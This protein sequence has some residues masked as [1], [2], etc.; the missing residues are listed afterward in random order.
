MAYCG[1]ATPGSKLRWGTVACCL[2]LGV[3]LFIRMIVEIASC[4]ICYPDGSCEKDFKPFEQHWENGRAWVEDGD[5]HVIPDASTHTLQCRDC[6]AP[7]SYC[8]VRCFSK[9]LMQ[10]SVRALSCTTTSCM[11]N[12]LAEHAAADP[13]EQPLTALNSIATADRVAHCVVYK[14]VRT[15][16]AEDRA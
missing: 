12:W 5:G 10:C 9:S 8:N 4:R 6:N 3:C 16:R 14:P 15:C 13:A 7:Q 11:F 2:V 1:C